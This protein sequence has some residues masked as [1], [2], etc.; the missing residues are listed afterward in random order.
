MSAEIRLDDPEAWSPDTRLVDLLLEEQQT[1]SA[2]DVFS[3]AHDALP[4][5]RSHYETL[6]PSRLPEIAEQFAFRVDLDACTGC[7]ACVT[8]CHSLNGL[9]EEETWRNVGLIETLPDA[10]ASGIAHQQTVTTACH[11]CEDPACMAGCPV[12][13]YEK[14][15]TTGIVRHLDD[16][17]IGCRY[18]QLTCPY[19]VPKYSERLGIVRKCDMCHDRLGAGEAP[20]CVQGC[21]NQ[22]ISISIVAT[23]E[24]SNRV[25]A[26]G[27]ALLPVV[28]GAMPSSALTRPST[29]Y[30][31][32]RAL[33]EPLYPAQLA[34]ASPSE[35]HTPLA[36]M[37]VLTQMSIG[38]LTLS[39][40]WTLIQPDVF[41]GGTGAQAAVQG[42]LLHAVALSLATVIGFAG[43]G[44]SIL[45]LGRPQWAFRAF[46]GLRTSWMSRE[47]IVLGGYA[48]LLAGACSLAWLDWAIQSERIAPLFPGLSEIAL[49]AS[50]LASLTGLLGLFCSVQIYAVTGRPL[51]RFDRTAI[52]F[53]STALL[54]G[55]GAFALALLLASAVAESTPTSTAQIRAAATLLSSAIAAFAL[56]KMAAESGPL[57]HA[58]REKNH[59]APQSPESIALERT[60]LLLTSSLAGAQKKRRLFGIGAA[61]GCFALGAATLPLNGPLGLSAGIAGLLLAGLVAGELIERSLFFR[62][63]AMPAMPRVN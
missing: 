3:A 43:L 7:K 44:A 21:P 54:L 18:C 40:L 50:L 29:E 31:S 60:R 11:H 1:L 2:V 16:Q 17:C 15:E 36:I 30:V 61:L 57:I 23:G 8:A 34:S 35:G 6:I 39:S 49:G 20:A 5:D 55:S 14:D 4:H 62:G 45:H 28:D 37:L 38:T 24:A 27:A 63:E 41:G 33:A 56:L 46:L 48:G 25:H 26:E 9:E 51:W 47:I 42:A 22:A 19:D 32:V 58:R 12:Q 53:G 59:E 52:R 10:A 13:A